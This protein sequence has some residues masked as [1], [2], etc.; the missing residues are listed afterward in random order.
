MMNDRDSGRW[1]RLAA[2]VLLVLGVGTVVRGMW[3]AWGGG[4]WDFRKRSAEYALYESGVYPNVR[5]RVPGRGVAGV[6][7][8]YPPYAFPMMSGFFRVGGP[9]MQRLGI[10]VVTLGAM[11][12]LVWRAREVLAGEGVAVR[13]W[14][15]AGVVLGFSG[16]L[17]AV[18]EGQF[19]ILGVGMLMLQ[20]MALERGRWRVAGMCWA[21]A[22]MKPHMALPFALLFPLGRQ[23]RGLALGMA[24][25][26]V[27]SAW[28]L[29]WTGVT[30]LAYVRAGVTSEK[31]TFVTV[32]Y[33]AG[34]WVDWTGISPRVA[35]LAGLVVVVTVVWGCGLEWVRVRVR[36][37]LIS[38]AAVAGLL[39]FVLFYHRPYDNLLLLPMWL[40]YVARMVERPTVM[41]WMVCGALGLTIYLP[42]GLVGRSPELQA[43]SLAGPVGAA[44]WMLVRGYG[45]VGIVETGDGGEGGGRDG[46]V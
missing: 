35:S 21:V 18:S 12:V 15:A 3:F 31:V 9:E 44:V 22:M 17:T 37:R 19:S 40:V 34:L 45:R 4:D 20:V 43:L 39:A 13:W 38:G 33:G 42:S 23:W 1:L 10:E 14:E 25:L 5:L 41:G 16:N 6:H 32:R 26:A 11:V 24:V 30:P 27:L 46:R 7:S 29:W 8:V 2:M 28:A 36:V